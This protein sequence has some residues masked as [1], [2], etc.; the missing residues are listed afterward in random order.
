MSANNN[1]PKI[2]NLFITYLSREKCCSEYLSF[3]LKTKLT[4]V[5]IFPLN[6]C[7]ISECSM[8]IWKLQFLKFLVIR[9]WSKLMIISTACL[10]KRDIC[11]IIDQPFIASLGQTGSNLWWLTEIGW[12]YRPNGNVKHRA[13]SVSINDGSLQWQ[14]SLRVACWISP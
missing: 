12:G 14:H 1:P 9:A 4:K 5:N 13:T 2:E 7:S 10:S 11:M 3:L 8:N 6:R